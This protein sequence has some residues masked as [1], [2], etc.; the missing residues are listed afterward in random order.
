M[1]IKLV[2]ECSFSVNATRH[3]IQARDNYTE[4]KNK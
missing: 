1:Q 3:I 4:I 2:F